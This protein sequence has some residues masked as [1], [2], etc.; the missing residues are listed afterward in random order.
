MAILGLMDVLAAVCG[1]LAVS[2]CGSSGPQEVGG[3]GMS[4]VDDSQACISQRSSALNEL[5]SDKQRSW[6]RQPAPAAAYA[7]GVRL[8]AFKQKKRELTCEEL[9]IGR[10]EAGAGPAILRGPQGQGLAT[11]QI[12]R[13]VMLAEEVGRELATESRRRCGA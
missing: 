9:Q 13:G 4:C 1:A 10:R 5:M 12:A 3:R 7:S 2:G 11:A 8:F 6:V